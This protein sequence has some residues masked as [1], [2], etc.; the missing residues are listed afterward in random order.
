MPAS[1]PLTIKPIPLPSDLDGATVLLADRDSYTVQALQQGF[2]AGGY[3]VLV[4]SSGAQALELLA[5]LRPNVLL[6]G[7]ELA[8]MDG[9]VVC[10]TV[11]ARG[12]GQFTPMILMA[13]PRQ[14]NP[15]GGPDYL[16]DAMI[17]KPVEHGELM[18]WLWH[19]LRMKQR[20]DRVQRENEQL[21]EELRE[22]EK[23]KSE[24]IT[25]VSHELRTPLV[26]VKAAVSLLAEEID[27]NG[28]RDQQI[29]IANMAT[30]AVARLESVIEN[31]RQL[32]QTQ[33][34]RLEPVAIEE[35]VDLAIRYLERSWKSRHAA[36]RVR[37]H[38]AAPLPPVWGDK[39]A[40]ARL[41]QLL[42]DN[43]LKFSSED[44][45]V[46]VLAKPGGNKTVLIG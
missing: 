31:I 39:K 23:L 22:V 2:E 32:D 13:S 16:V 21:L 7:T 14:V 41:L 28:P 25:V 5:E 15:T 17:T 29:Q 1:P 44:S 8:D 40:L 4:T 26:Q 3:R 43:A 36:E 42:L 11:R 27:K 37:K 9:L 35:S 6:L 10:R 33:R 20:F 12:S 34:V 24:I 45:L 19:L 46:F 38:L 30:Q 18:K